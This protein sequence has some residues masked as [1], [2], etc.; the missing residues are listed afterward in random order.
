MLDT[1]KSGVAC[2]FCHRLVDPIYDPGANPVEDAAILAALSMPASNFAN[3]MATIDPTGARRGPCPL[4]IVGWR[5]HDVVGMSEL[6]GLWTRDATSC[7][8][9]PMRS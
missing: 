5:R 7:A 8:R 1:D 4:G 3:G 2:D 6:R 9:S